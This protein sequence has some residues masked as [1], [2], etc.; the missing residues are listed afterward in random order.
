MIDKEM[1]CTSCDTEATFEAIDGNGD[2][3]PSV[4]SDNGRYCDCGAFTCKNCTQAAQVGWPV[5]DT[6]Q[7]P[8][9]NDDTP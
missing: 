7:C 8:V 5:Y 6:D 4:V 2:I 9:C 1:H 3:P